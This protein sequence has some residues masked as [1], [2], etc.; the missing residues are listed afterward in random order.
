[1]LRPGSGHRNEARTT[2]GRVGAPLP[3][4]APQGD[5]SAVTAT[6]AVAGQAESGRAARRQV[7]RRSHAHWAPASDRPDPIAQLEEQA[8]SRDPTLVPIRHGRMA[9]S[10]FAFFRG[11]AYVMA[12]DLAETPT[13]GITVQLCGD[14]HLSNFGGF[15]A[16]DRQLVFDLNDF[17]ETLPGPWEWDVKRLVASLA[18]AGRDRGF[19]PDQRRLVVATAARTYRTA[20]RDFAEMGNVEVWYSRLTAA[21]IAQQW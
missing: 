9:A 16:P 12:A 11:A 10:A 2:Q 21:N 6:A 5:A 1:M 13:S 15:A 19:T 8:E 4:P 7:P 3:R 14:A 18:I 20:M 17:D